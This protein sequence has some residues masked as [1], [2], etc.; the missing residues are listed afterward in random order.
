MIFGTGVDMVEIARIKT[1][2]DKYGKKF[3]ERIFSDTEI[4]YSLSKSN[5]KSAM[6]SLAARFAA[7]EAFVKALGTGVIK[8]INLKY[9]YVEIDDK[10]KPHIRLT[11]S[12]PYFDENSITNVHLSLSHTNEHAI[13]T[14]VLEK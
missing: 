4:E 10:G 6:S 12:I 11:R 7:K 3:L 5:V 14:V 2:Y 1:L 13:A 9:I 8:H